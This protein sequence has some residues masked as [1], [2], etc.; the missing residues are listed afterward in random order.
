MGPRNTRKLWE[1]AKLA[2]GYNSVLLRHGVYFFTVSKHDAIRSL[3][4][5][6]VLELALFTHFKGLWDHYSELPVSVWCLVRDLA[7]PSALPAQTQNQLPPYE[8]GIPDYP[9]QL[10]CQLTAVIDWA[11]PDW[12]NHQ[13]THGGMRNNT[14]L[15]F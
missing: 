13:L 3:K 4:R 11:G 12:K 15:L 6:C 1:I 9:G 2:T 10:R 5:A 8:W 14:F 7:K